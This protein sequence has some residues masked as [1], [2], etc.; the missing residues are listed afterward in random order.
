MMQYT[1]IISADESQNVCID[2]DGVIHDNYDGFG[3]GT[4]YGPLIDGAYE[5]LENLSKKYNIIIFTAKAKSDR[6]LID[7][8]T[9]SHL[10]WE[11][12]KKHNLAQ[13]VKQVTAEKPRGLVYIDDKALRFVDWDS[14]MKQFKEI[15]E[16]S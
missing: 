9:G 15:Y 13:F 16:G 7:S 10:V 4:I 5:S 12:L 2:F 6:P 14:T 3:D 8:K 11:W 1:D